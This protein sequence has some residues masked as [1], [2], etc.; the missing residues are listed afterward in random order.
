MAVANWWKTFFDSDYARLWG[1]FAAAE[2]DLAQ[3]D[4][5]WQ[6]LNLQ[7]GSRVLDAPC[8]YGRLS[9][10]LAERGASVVGVDQSEVLLKRA[11]ENRGAIAPS[12]LRYIRHDLRE[13]LP[14][15]GFDAAF[16]V[17][18]SIGYGTEEDDLA[19]LKALRAALRP[20]GLLFL[21]TAHRDAFIALRLQGGP[22]PRRLADGTLIVEECL[23]DPVAGRNDSSWFWYG[24]GG[25]GEKSASIRLYTATELVR[26]LE[27][28]GLRF[29]SAHSGCSLA[30]FKAETVNMGGR[31]GILAEAHAAAE[32][33]EHA[34]HRLS[35]K[36]AVSDG[37]MK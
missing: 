1:E 32:H 12:S 29:R 18:T 9:V 8:G 37:K 33:A 22:P 13:P 23:F 34:T 31:L 3:A 5:L 25:N 14:E 27:L 10:L 11:E 24:P 17:F 30:P 4:A 21:D 35:C 6:L 15:R 26:L 7:E 20:G 36:L 16:N 2:A 28:A 19:I